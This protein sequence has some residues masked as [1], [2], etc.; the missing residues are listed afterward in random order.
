MLPSF[1]DI[2]YFLEVTETHNISRAAERLGITQPSLSA[3]IKR[4]EDSLGVELLLRSRTGVQLTKSGKDFQSRGR[5]LLLN[6]E[7]LR[8][9]INKRQA[10]VSGEYIIGCHPSVA[11]YSLSNFLPKLMLDHPGL[12][13]KLV[14]DLS[15]KITEGVVSFEIDFGIVVN[16]I[17]HPDLVIKELCTDEIQFW[18]SKKNFG[19]QSMESRQNILI[20]D[21]DLIQVQKLMSELQKKKIHFGRTIRSGNLEVI[22]NLTAE[23]AGV[24]VLPRRVATRLESYDLKPFSSKLPSFKDRICLVYRSDLQKTKGAQQVISAIKN[25]KL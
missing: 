19:R 10:D 7:Q 20:C 3:A 18:I 16:P 12:E 21:P 22:A 15:R 2:T 17:Q 24:G 23:G 13:L 1:T 9:D 8:A 14:H 4:L 25:A 6:W 11:L 5:F